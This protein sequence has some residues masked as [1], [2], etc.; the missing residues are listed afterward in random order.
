[1]RLTVDLDYP[2]ELVKLSSYLNCLYVC[3]EYGREFE[4]WR[5]G[6]KKDPHF[7]VY[8]LP[9]YDPH[10][11]GVYGDDRGRVG[12]DIGSSL[13]PK[14]VMYSLRDGGVRERGDERCLLSLPWWSRVPKRCA[15][16][17]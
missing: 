9:P 6:R 3:R 4:Y 10:L 17:C 2:S 15:G 13:K 14:Q 7:V 11:R 8:G 12:F 16:R 5:S 1:M